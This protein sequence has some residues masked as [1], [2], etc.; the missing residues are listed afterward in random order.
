V[1]LEVNQQPVSNVSQVQRELQR[2]GAGQPVFLLIWRVNQAG[3]GQTVF[4]TMSR[5]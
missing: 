2:A 1:I 5:R 4:V 3:E